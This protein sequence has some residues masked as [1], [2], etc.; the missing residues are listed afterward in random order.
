MMY[1]TSTSL[2][3]IPKEPVQQDD[4]RS[5]FHRGRHHHHHHHIRDFHFHLH[6][7]HFYR[8]HLHDFRCFADLFINYLD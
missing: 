3:W 6:R 4:H 8:H 5:C 2:Q 1:S 7:H